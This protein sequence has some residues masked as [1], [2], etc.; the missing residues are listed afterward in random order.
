MLLRKPHILVAGFGQIKLFI[1]K[2]LSTCWLV[3]I[4]SIGAKQTARG[5]KVINILIHLLTVRATITTGV[6][7]CNCEYNSGTNVIV[8]TNYFLILFKYLPQEEAQVLYYKF[9]QEFIV[10][11]LIHPWP[12][13]YYSFAKWT[14]TQTL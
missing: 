1:T 14:Q 10:E 9:S 8:V 3:I 6:V 13:Y 11:S 5:K 2:H 4:I 7:R 12:P